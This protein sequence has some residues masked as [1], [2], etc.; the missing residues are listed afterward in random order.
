MAVEGV[1]PEALEE[2]VHTGTCLSRALTGEAYERSLTDAGFRVI[3]RWDATDGLRELLR[4]IKRNLV[5]VAFA[6]A[7]G[8]LNG[9]APIDMKYA[10]GVLR[11]AERALDA[12][13]IRYTA[14]IAERLP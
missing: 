10:R 8:Q 7:S 5:G 13:T 14:M 11:E 9:V 4:R 6:A 3:E 2:W 12:G 1:I